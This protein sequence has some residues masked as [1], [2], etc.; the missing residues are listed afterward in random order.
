MAS[1]AV[2]LAEVDLGEDHYNPGHGVLGCVHGLTLM[3]RVT[4]FE[5]I[6]H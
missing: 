5:G 6:F 4:K 1:N 2:M 3:L